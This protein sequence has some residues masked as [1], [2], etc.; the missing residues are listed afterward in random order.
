M[1]L[2]LLATSILFFWLAPETS[3]HEADNIMEVP[4]RSGIARW[5]LTAM[6]FIKV[7][8]YGKA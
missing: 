6:G 3:K 1:F 5:M 4:S 7:K 8:R 2:H